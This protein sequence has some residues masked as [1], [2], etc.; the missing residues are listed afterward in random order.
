[1]NTNINWKVR[2]NNPVFWIQIVVTIVAT[3][4]TYANLT[5]ADLTNW[6]ALFDMFKSV[7]TNPVLLFQVGSAL[8]NAINDPTTGGVGDSERAMSYVAPGVTADE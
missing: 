2:L 6:A 8:W 7:F 5:A 4:M 3:V 1:M